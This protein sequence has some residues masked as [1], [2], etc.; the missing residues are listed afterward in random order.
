MAQFL[1]ES[2]ELEHLGL[3]LKG[4]IPRPAAQPARR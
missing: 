3:P 4:Y 1:S 2:K